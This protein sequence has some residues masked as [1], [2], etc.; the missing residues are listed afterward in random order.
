[1]SSAYV[2]TQP[3]A[4]SIEVDRA[5][6]NLQL[7]RILDEFLTEAIR[8]PGALPG[9]LPDE[10][11]HHWMWPSIGNH[12]DPD[13]VASAQ[14]IRLS[15]GTTSIPREFAKDGLDWEAEQEQDAKSMGLDLV[16]YRR[17]LV[18]KRFGSPGGDPNQKPGTPGS[19]PASADEET[20]ADD[21]DEV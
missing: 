19:K 7:D 5:G 13:K 15:S 12:A 20:E 1:M 8:V 3:F 18:Q 4:R 6:Y 2:V 9:E 10:F 11:P 21:I 17:L 16:E 14:Q